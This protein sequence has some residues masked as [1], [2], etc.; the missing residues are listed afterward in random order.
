MSV[1]QSIV[2]DFVYKVFKH[3][4]TSPHTFLCVF[5]C[6]VKLKEIRPM[7]RFLNITSL[8]GKLSHYIFILQF[9]LLKKF[10]ILTPNTINFLKSTCIVDI[11]NVVG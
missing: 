5:V 7:D 2:I 11:Q 4:V 8:F 10:P 6:I 1:K 3:P 9:P